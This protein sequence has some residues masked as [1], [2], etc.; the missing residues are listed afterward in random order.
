MQSDAHRRITKFVEK[1]RDEAVQ[2]EFKMGPEL[3][4]SIGVKFDVVPSHIPEEHR[5]GRVLQQLEL[6]ED[7]P[8]GDVH[9]KGLGGDTRAYEV[10]KDLYRHTPPAVPAPRAD[11]TQ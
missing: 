1:P 6:S 3:L 11:K 10:S 4:A 9:Q 7:R 8:T 2:N 5:A